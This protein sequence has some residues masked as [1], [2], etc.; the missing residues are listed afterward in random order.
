MRAQQAAGAVV[1]EL[2]RPLGPPRDDAAEEE[3]EEH[4]HGRV[5]QQE[6]PRALAEGSLHKAVFQGWAPCQNVFD[7]TLPKSQVPLEQSQPPQLATIFSS[8]LVNE[9]F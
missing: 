8:I 6:Q 7:A 1:C 2:T 5:A 9:L 4:A 3:V